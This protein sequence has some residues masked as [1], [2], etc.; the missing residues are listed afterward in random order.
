M[1]SP[2]ENEYN[3]NKPN[4]SSDDNDLELL[5]CKEE[6]KSPTTLLQTSNKQ[7]TKQV[8]VPSSAPSHRLLMNYSKEEEE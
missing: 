2:D 1:S 3:D 4:K 5:S 6:L 7:L 8:V